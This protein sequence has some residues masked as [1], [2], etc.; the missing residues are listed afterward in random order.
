MP[1]NFVTKEE[2]KCRVLK[3]KH[4]IDWEQSATQGERDMAHR[5]LNYVLQALEEYRGWQSKKV[6]LYYDFGCINTYS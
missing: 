4:E 6:R 5:Y 2:L 3:L 1:K